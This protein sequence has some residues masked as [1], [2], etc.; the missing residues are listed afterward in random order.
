MDINIGTIMKINKK[1]LC[2]IFLFF[3]FV[4]LSGFDNLA[5]DIVSAVCVIFLIIFY[6]SVRSSFHMMTCVGY[7]VYIAVP[8]FLHKIFNDTKFE[9]FYITSFFVMMLLIGTQ[10]TN[11]NDLACKGKRN[12]GMYYWGLLGAAVLLSIN[13]NLFVVYVP[14]LMVLMIRAF[15]IRKLFYNFYLYFLFLTI[16][17][18]YLYY[19]WSGYGR[20]VVAGILI[21]A[22]LYLFYASHLRFSKY[23]LMVLTSIAPFAMAGRTS[24]D[25]SNIDLLSSLN[26]SAFGPYGQ[27]AEFAAN[28]SYDLAGLIDQW[29][30]TL[31]VFIPRAVWS[32][33][34]YG[35]GFEYTV[36]HL[37]WSYIDAG[38][39]IAATFVGEHLYFMGYW[40]FI[41]AGLMV[42]LISCLVNFFNKLNFLHGAGVS[43]IS[44]NVLAL[45]WGGMTSFSARMAFSIIVFLVI[46]F[47]YLK[48]SNKWRYTFGN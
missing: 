20:T 8:A 15:E 11:F 24:F 29:I 2:Q 39:S 7:S 21:C 25:F 13:A 18:A 19:A 1:T 44:A 16:Y 6:A 27:A 33:K 22:T 37:D 42:F 48:F 12:V 38:H 26:D 28:A 32:E 4:L 43:I 47:F 14:F 5:L 30:F 41:S 9:L 17:L 36:R 31:F 45:V 35:F 34:P 46:Y 10:S 3:C 23:L 40:G